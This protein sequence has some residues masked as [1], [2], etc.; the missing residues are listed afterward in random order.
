MQ[1][2][3]GADAPKAKKKTKKKDAEKDD[4]IT[5]QYSKKSYQELSNF[6]AH[7]VRMK[8]DH[9][10]ADPLLPT[11][12]KEQ[13]CT[14]DSAE[15]AYQQCKLKNHYFCQR[16]AAYLAD[17]MKD[18][19]KVKALGG[20]HGR[21]NAIKYGVKAPVIRPEGLVQEE[22][23]Q[24]MRKVLAAKWE[25]NPEVQKALR[26]T[27]D[28]PLEHSGGRGKPGLWTVCYSNAEEAK[29]GENMLGKLW[30]EVRAAHP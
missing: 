2:D 15:A 26:G 28:R 1:K 24:W 9:L 16:S 8:A 5:F 23:I 14:F 29:V 25:Q 30:M 3:A 13:G 7:P 27:G 21:K 4:V 10:L 22:Q 19:V 18:S 12:C 11:E 6:S 17:V 20:K